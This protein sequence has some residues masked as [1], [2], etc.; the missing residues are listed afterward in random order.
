MVNH[1]LRAAAAIGILAGASV[2]LPV[3]PVHAAANCQFEETAPPPTETPWA[4]TRLEPRTVWPL[5]RGEGVIVAVIDSGVA[6]HHVA[7]TENVIRGTDFGFDDAG[8][9]CDRAGHGTLVAGIIAGDDN[10]EV[11][12]YGVAPAAKILP[13]RVLEEEGTSNDPE[14]PLRIARA[15]TWAADQ[16]GVRVIN[17]SLETVPIDELKAAVDYAVKVKDIVVVAAAGNKAEGE[18]TLPAFPA[19]YDDVIAVAGIKPDGGH[20]DSSV[21]GDYIDLAAPGLEITG[22]A[23]SA[24]GYQ[25][26]AEGGTSY[27]APYVAGTAALVRAHEPALNA[28]QVGERLRKTADHPPGGKDNQIGYGVVNPYRAVSTLLGNREALPPGGLAAPAP[29]AADP[30]ATVR[31]V[32]V[33]A[34]A[35]VVLLVAILFGSRPVLHHG[36]QHGWR[37]RRTAGNDG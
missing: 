27:A 25:F 29:P 13:V 19:A 7:L 20:V 32:A 12:F 17:L 15:I 21:S 28:A 36:R 2:L 11:P 37:P 18:R 35:L 26:Q 5:T 31:L 16:P 23:P 14:L 22:P 3:A 4:L 33:W 1:R 24:E 30:L 10:P 6:A 34:A 9:Q 8:G